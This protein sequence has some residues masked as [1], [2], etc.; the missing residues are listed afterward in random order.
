MLLSAQPPQIP[1]PFGAACVPADT[2]VISNTSLIG[3]ITGAASR[4]DGFPPLCFADPLAGGVAPRGVD[5]NGILNELSAAMW[6]EQAGGQYPYSAAYST[7]IGGYPL[8]AVV[9]RTDGTGWW[10]NTVDGNTSD[11]ETFGGG[12]FPCGGGP[13]PLALSGLAA[14][15]KT[16][17]AL[18][19]ATQTIVLT[20]TLTANITLTLPVW[21]GMQ[22]VFIN[23]C[24]G[25]FTVTLSTGSGPMVVVPQAAGPLPVYGRASG[26]SLAAASTAWAVGLPTS[27]P[28]TAGVVWNNGGTVSIS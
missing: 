13:A 27:L 23:N 4:P 6:W 17:T 15:N 19:A 3:I 18:Q 12:W 14:T 16:L 2:T 1:L 9:G 11:P 21:V 10:Q 7:A 22:W 20:G 28:A 26:L 25:A 24:T 8:N 5:F